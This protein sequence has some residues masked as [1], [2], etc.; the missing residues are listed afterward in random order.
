MKLKSLLTATALCLAIVS[1][2]HAKATFLS[3]SGPW[4]AFHIDVGSEG[5]PMCGMMVT[6]NQGRM[7]MVKYQAGTGTMAMNFA[8]PSWRF[9]QGVEVSIS[10]KFD[11]SEYSGSAYSDHTGRGDPMLIWGIK[12]GSEA[13]FLREF[14][15]AK[16]LTINFPDGNEPPWVVNMTGSR[17]TAETFKKCSAAIDP[18]G[19]TQPTGKQQP[20]KDGKKKDN[21][22]V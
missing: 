18:A 13:D 6:G 14:S 19:A 16:K 8:K 2:A 9:K 21:G 12:E 22:E 10:V 1:G 5:N 17:A 15:D 7:F 4:S 11:D 3:R 20:N